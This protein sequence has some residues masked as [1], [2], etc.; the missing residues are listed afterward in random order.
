MR[1][2]PIEI[3]KT[4]IFLDHSI[5]EFIIADRGSLEGLNFAAI[6]RLGVIIMDGF[7]GL[8]DAGDILDGGRLAGVSVGIG[9][10]LVILEDLIGNI[11][12]HF[13]IHSHLR[14]IGL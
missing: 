12:A 6:G 7:F 2:R 5:A 10:L 4:R 9:G 13:G 14:E 3:I 11:A 1:H 8:L